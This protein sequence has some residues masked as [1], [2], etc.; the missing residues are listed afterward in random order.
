MAQI[1]L[2]NLTTTWV[3]FSDIETPTPDTE[4]WIQNRGAD[5]LLACEGSAEPTTDE[6]ICVKPYETLKYVKGTENLYLRA[7]RTTCTINVSSGE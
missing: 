7:Y 6:G 1:A 2:E 3:E 5:F 4:Y